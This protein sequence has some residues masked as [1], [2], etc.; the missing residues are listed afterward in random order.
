M[1][2]KYINKL[3]NKFH[4]NSTLYNCDWG[5][6]FWLPCLTIARSQRGS[7]VGHLG[8]C[9]TPLVSMRNGRSCS[10]EPVTSY[11]CSLWHFNNCRYCISW[12][13]T[14]SCCISGC[15][16]WRLGEVAAEWTFEVIVGSNHWPEGH[17]SGP[18]PCACHLCK[19][20]A[21]WLLC[22]TSFC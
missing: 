17:Q 11:V 21:L 12:A 8:G 18:L 14:S 1:H 16:E 4:T 22:L 9:P 5:Q 13:S 6:S 20:V 7:H 3:M 10:K 19:F 15:P 2:F